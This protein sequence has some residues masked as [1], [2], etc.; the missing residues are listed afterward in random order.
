MAGGKI[1][2]HRVV[3][4]VGII[5]GS[6]VKSRHVGHDLWGTLLFIHILRSCTTLVDS[7]LICAE[8]MQHESWGSLDNR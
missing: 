8:T 6:S 1:E 3:K 7:V 4:E 2:G 5:V